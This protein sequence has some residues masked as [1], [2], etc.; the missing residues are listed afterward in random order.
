MK[1]PSAI[2]LILI[3]LVSSCKK[4]NTNDPMDIDPLSYKAK[5]FK[6][7][8]GNPFSNSLLAQ[9]INSQLKFTLNF[10][11]TFD[12]NNDP[13]LVQTISYSKDNNDTTVFLIFDTVSN[14]LQT[15]YTEVGGVKQP[16]V[17]KHEY[18]VGSDTS[19]RL[20]IYTY[21]WSNNTAV[22]N[23]Q[24]LVTAKSLSPMY[25]N[26][27]L[28]DIAFGLGVGIGVAGIVYTVANA[29]AIGAAIVAAAPAILVTM[30]ATGAIILTLEFISNAQAA[31]LDPNNGPLPPNTP[32]NNPTNGVNNPSPNL[33]PSL[34]GS[35]YIAFAAKRD[36]QGNITVLGASGGKTPYT[37]AAGSL[38]FQTSQVISSPGPATSQLVFVK[39]AKGCISGQL[40]NFNLPFFSGI[41]VAGGNGPGSGLNQIMGIR[42]LDGSQ[43]Q[44]F[45]GRNQIQVRNGNI[46]IM[47]LSNKRILK[48]PIGAQSGTIIASWQD[49][50]Q[51]T[52]VFWGFFV[53]KK[54]N[55][56]ISYQNRVE[57]N[58]VVVA[59]GD[60]V[61]NPSDLSIIGAP[62]KIFV[63]DFDNLYV[64]NGI[65]YNI[66]KWVPGAKTGVLVAGGNGPGPGLNQL[67]A[68]QGLVVDSVG[69]VFV[70]NSYFKSYSPLSGIPDFSRILKYVPGSTTGIVVVD[71]T[72]SVSGR[73]L[74]PLAWG[75]DMDSKGN[76][77]V[78]GVVGID[79]W[80]PGTKIEI[81]VAGG[82]GEGPAANQLFYPFDVKVDP[83]GNIYVYDW[84]NARVQK[85]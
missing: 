26:R 51:S 57:K 21:N 5:V 62:W 22:L 3:L 27:S 63:D 58:G 6:N 31:D 37:Y 72:R 53:D 7:T 74:E 82:F 75:M 78:V 35:S 84:G 10:Y 69:N 33:P 2:F 29:A 9:V 65:K 14:R 77:F 24:T 32:I 41:T 56:Y 47:D 18:I 23:F 68:V 38:N 30:A 28:K 46:Y 17:L 16:I 67:Y 64:N 11:G 55:L 44:S 39:D 80:T 85:W 54:D 71:S 52:E 20:S 70:K 76:I 15:V 42:A 50:A 59:I 49:N 12:S 48:W 45:S 79:K 83:F 13:N 36:G 1:R 43:L 25:L 19:L 73:K 4:N 66:T 40:I 60:D 81:T 8:T 34:C 61:R